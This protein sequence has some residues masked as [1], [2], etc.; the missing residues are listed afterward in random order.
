MNISPETVKLLQ[1]HGWD[2]LRVS[3]VLL[4][5]ATDLEVL[6]FARREQRILIT[7]DLDFSALLALSG[8]SCP[9]LVTLRLPLPEPEVVALRLLKVI[10]EI[11]PLLLEGGAV[12][13]E[14]NV[15][16]IRR[17]PIELQEPPPG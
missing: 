9:S 15:V 7:Q 2:I 14:E 10:P 1:E 16:R 4:A 5:G 12:T 8:Y 17:L 6:E 3:E 13:V 11:E